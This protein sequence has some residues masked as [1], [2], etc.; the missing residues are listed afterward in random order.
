[1]HIAQFNVSLSV[2]MLM[3]VLGHQYAPLHSFEH[4]FWLET[5]Q[6]KLKYSQLVNNGIPSRMDPRQVGSQPVA[7]TMLGMGASR[8]LRALC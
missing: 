1:M 8:L 2:C 4:S 7:Q 5:N 3:V 6:A